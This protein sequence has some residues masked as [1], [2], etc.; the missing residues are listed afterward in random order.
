MYFLNMRSG[1]IVLFGLLLGPNFASAATDGAPSPGAYILDQEAERF[2][3]SFR[4]GSPQERYLAESLRQRNPKMTVRELVSQDTYDWIRRSHA[5]WSPEVSAMRI[6]LGHQAHLTLNMSEDEIAIYA[7]NHEAFEFSPIFN[8]ALSDEIKQTL[9]GEIYL[10]LDLLKKG[11]RV[12]SM[13]GIGYLSASEIL[14]RLFLVTQD[15]KLK[16]TMQSVLIGAGMSAKARKIVDRY[17]I[18]TVEAF[19]QKTPDLVRRLKPELVREFERARNT[20]VRRGFSTCE[21]LIEGT[22]TESP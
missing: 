12:Q 22:S 1:A 10:V 20:L 8:L 18:S 2:L 9:A 21:T 17:D 6:A 11:R 19:I 14:H 4:S 7:A 3:L 15:P 5:E 16:P 13:P